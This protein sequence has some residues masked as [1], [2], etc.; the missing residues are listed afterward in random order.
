MKLLRLVLCLV[1]LVGSYEATAATGDACGGA[2]QPACPVPN[3]YVYA[4]GICDTLLGYPSPQPC[5]LANAITVWN[6]GQPGTSCVTGTYAMGPF[7]I[8]T[9]NTA[10]VISA[11]SANLPPNN[12]IGDGAGLLFGRYTEGSMQTTCGAGTPVTATIA[13]GCA[14]GAHT[15][16]P[17]TC[18]LIVCGA[19]VG[20]FVDYRIAHYGSSG[21]A[22]GTVDAALLASIQNGYYGAKQC[23]QGCRVRATRSMCFLVANDPTTSDVMCDLTGM[24]V[25]E[26]C[27]PLD[28]IIQPANIMNERGSI[29]NVTGLTGTAGGGAGTTGSTTADGINLARIATNTARMAEG[30]NRPIRVTVEG[31]GGT[32]GSSCGG[33]GQPAC[34]INE[35]NTSSTAASTATGM[36]GEKDAMGALVQGRADAL[37]VDSAPAFAPGTGFW[38]IGLT[39]FL[40]AATCELSLGTLTLGVMTT[41]TLNLSVCS[42]A[43]YVQSF[44]YWTFGVL[45]LFGLWHIVFA[46]KAS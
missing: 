18:G 37:K 44:F 19:K 40:P 35:G 45:T 2:G 32:G 5:P 17:G 16:N 36:T 9:S 8:D 42:W 15:N 41:G 3:G 25:S 30:L 23:I 22:T 28:P 38:N 7:T 11:I 39:S 43:P 34:S 21:V 33:P 24:Y 46:S 13:Y 12:P 20:K 6:S 26:S 1:A 4:S 14:N 29:D 31:E 27:V 10:A